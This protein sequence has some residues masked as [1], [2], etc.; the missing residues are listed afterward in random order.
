MKKFLFLFLALAFLPALCG[1]GSESTPEA[2]GS[3]IYFHDESGAPLS[4]W[5]EI[6]GRTYYLDRDGQAAAGIAELDGHTYLF[7]TDGVMATGLTEYGGKI[8]YLR[9]NGTMVTGWF[10]LDGQRYYLTT[11]GAAVGVTQV[12][13][14][15]YVFDSAGRLT[16]GWA[17]FPGGKAWGDENGHPVTGWQEIDGARYHFGENGILST[18]WT[19]ID[20]WEYYFYG[21]GTPAQGKL[22]INGQKYCFASSGQRVILVNP[23]NT[24]PEGYTTELVTIS[25]DHQIAAIAYEDCAAMLA[26]CAEAGMQPVVVSGYRTQEY[27]EDLYQRRIDRYIDENGYTPEKA[28]EMAGWSVAIPGTSEHQLGLAVDIV[29]NRNWNLD[30]SQEKMPTQ[31]WLMENSWRY[32]WILRYPAGKSALTGIIYEPWHYRYV[33]R[34]VAAEIHELGLCLEEY[35]LMLTPSVG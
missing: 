5:Q 18:G 21:D 23:R 33:G 10:S 3:G 11:G 17:E 2:T 19:L 26:D 16:S 8:Y 22:E 32:G 34:E 4:G 28:R 31:Q 29:D 9:T 30:N 7:G 14:R 35:L 27:Q 15:E 6:D 12:E 1:C 20:G 24:I 13:D 25:G